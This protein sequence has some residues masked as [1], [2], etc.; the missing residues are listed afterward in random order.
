ML[1]KYTVFG[2][3]GTPGA[4]NVEKSSSLRDP[5]PLALARLCGPLEEVWYMTQND[6]VKRICTVG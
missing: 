2:P 4:L 5:L 1:Y 6:A 3:S